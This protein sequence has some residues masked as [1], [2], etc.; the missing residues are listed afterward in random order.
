MPWLMGAALGARTPIAEFMPR[1]RE[2][3]LE[4]RFPSPNSD[5]DR[6][7]RRWKRAFSPTK[8]QKQ[9][10]LAGGN[11][12]RSASS[13]R[14]YYAVRIVSRRRRSPWALD[15][16]NVYCVIGQASNRTRASSETKRGAPRQ[17]CRRCRTAVE[18]S[19][20][21]TKCAMLARESI[22]ARVVGGSKAHSRS[23]SGGTRGGRA[24]DTTIEIRRVCGIVVAV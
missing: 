4:A 13:R 9:K 22:F 3:A 16:G 19:I 11:H 10:K 6:G 8:K 12:A 24:R 23:R 14:R 5:H 18:L 20:A 1:L 21:V 17:C 2:T 7:E 15:R